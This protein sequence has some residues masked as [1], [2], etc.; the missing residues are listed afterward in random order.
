MITGEPHP[1]SH[2]AKIGDTITLRVPEKWEYYSPKTGEVYDTPEEFGTQNYISRP[3][4]YHDEIF[5]VEALVL[6]PTN[7]CYRYY[8]NDEF[9]LNAET[10]CEMT[11]KSDV[12]LYAFDTDDSVEA[13]MEE[14]LHNYTENINSRYGYESKQ[15]YVEEFESF[16]SMF[17]T[18]GGLLSFIVG[19]VGVLNFINAILTGIL[20]RKRELAML[21]SIGMTGKQ[22]KTMLV[23]E[24]LLYAIGSVVLASIFFVAVSPLAALV[25]EKLFWFFSYKPTFIPILIVAPIFA[26][27][28]CVVPLLVYRSVSKLT[29][30]ERLRESEQ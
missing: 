20:T 26:I 15:T 7:L 13:S 21:Q 17:L 12:M 4:Q 3:S 24:G 11:G 8:G 2:W 30:V 28:G 10:F 5:T 23:T 18:V 22:L 1:N 27:V 9:V 29:I 16:R 19:M 14:F 25:L 6:V